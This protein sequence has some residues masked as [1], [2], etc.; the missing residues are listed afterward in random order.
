MTSAAPVPPE[1]REFLQPSTAKGVPNAHTAQARAGI[2]RYSETWRIL[3]GYLRASIEL[4][5]DALEV[6]G[7]PEV[8]AALLRG[9]IVACRALLSIGDI[10]RSPTIDRTNLPHLD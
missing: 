9:Q 2:D 7:L 1:V 4:H 6:P 8:D 3:V 5:R 10:N